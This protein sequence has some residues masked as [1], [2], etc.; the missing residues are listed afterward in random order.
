ML[1]LLCRNLELSN[2]ARLLSSRRRAAA[3]PARPTIA[4]H[5]FVGV[6]R[7]QSPSP[8]TRA[9]LAWYGCIGGAAAA[10]LGFNSVGL[11]GT[12]RAAQLHKRGERQL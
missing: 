9:L 10:E 1:L 5:C 2:T 12:A 8:A 4:R 7:R 11:P 6:S 3:P